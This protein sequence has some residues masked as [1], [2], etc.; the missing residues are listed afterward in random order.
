MAKHDY[1]EIL[2]VSKNASETEIKRAYR[3]L[4]IKYHPDKNKSAEATEKF[5][6]IN[7]AYEI[8]SNPQ[9]KQTYD[10]FG[11]AA[12]DSSS[13]FGTGQASQKGPFTYTYTTSGSSPFEGINVDFRGFT[14][15]FEIFESFFGGA[16]PFRRGPQ[17]PVYSFTLSFME[18]VKGIEKTIVHQGKTRKI[19]IP[20]GVDN[21]VQIKF[22]DFIVKINVK[23]HPTFKRDGYDIFTTQE[24]TFSQAALGTT[25]NIETIT[26]P[27]NIKIRPGTQ[28]GTLIRLRGKG[29]SHPRSLRHGDHYIR[30]VVKVP[31]KLTRE[32]KRLLKQFQETG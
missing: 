30:L 8:L 6:E 13:G 28:S 19:K 32:Q 4:A 22:K 25:I 27:L 21:G 20:P 5:K 24:I 18:A 16:S 7:E 9:K 1:Y 14:D 29:I 12:F 23:N 11:H 3:K 10:Q 2:G 31:Q 26:K 17:L 15:P